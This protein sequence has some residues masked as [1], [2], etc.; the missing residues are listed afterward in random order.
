MR[1]ALMKSIA[2]NTNF[3]LKFIDCLRVQH[4]EY[5]KRLF[6][7]FD[8]NYDYTLKLY[9]KPLYL[10]NGNNVLTRRYKTKSDLFED[11]QKIDSI[12]KIDYMHSL[13]S[14]QKILSRKIEK[15]NYF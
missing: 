2:G 13:Q 11:V 6:K 9:Y 10:Y 3:Q 14:M 4:Y 5:H 7:I 1:I 12:Q 8:R 15:C